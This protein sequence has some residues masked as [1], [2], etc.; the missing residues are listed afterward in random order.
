[1]KAVVMVVGRGKGHWSKNS[2]VSL[3]CI[4][5]GGSEV[6]WEVIYVEHQCIP[7][8]SALLSAQPSCDSTLLIE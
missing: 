2:T 7:Q 6:G 4:R 8:E 5:S 1:M 3:L